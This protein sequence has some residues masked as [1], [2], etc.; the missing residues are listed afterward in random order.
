MTIKK[1]INYNGMYH[2]NFSIMSEAAF[3]PY[4][5]KVRTDIFC[6]VIIAE[7]GRVKNFGKKFKKLQESWFFTCRKILLKKEKSVRKFFKE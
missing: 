2:T 1:Y 5:A 3:K 7:G 6:S 4:S